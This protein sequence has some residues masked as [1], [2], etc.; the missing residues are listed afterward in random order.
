MGMPPTGSDT[1]GTATDETGDFGSDNISAERLDTLTFR[2]IPA[3]QEGRVLVIHNKA[4]DTGESAYAVDG[5]P[6]KK[7]NLAWALGYPGPLSTQWALETLA[8]LLQETIGGRVDGSADIA[9]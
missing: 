7:G 8:P 4:F 5:Q 2:A 6:E 1:T 3:V 9:G